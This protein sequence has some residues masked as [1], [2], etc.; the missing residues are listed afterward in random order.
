M[1]R[2]ESSAVRTSFNDRASSMPVASMAVYSFQVKRWSGSAGAASFSPSAAAASCIARICSFLRGQQNHLNYQQQQRSHYQR[3]QHQHQ[4]GGIMPVC[5]CGG[6]VHSPHFTSKRSADLAQTLHDQVLPLTPR[7]L[8]FFFC[9]L[10]T[11]KS[12][13]HCL[14]MCIPQTM[15]SDPICSHVTSY[16]ST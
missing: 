5:S 15:S 6:Q 7:F 8:C 2:F 13:F 11:N 14:C 10:S 3:H 12:F 4:E 1:C 16:S 9:H